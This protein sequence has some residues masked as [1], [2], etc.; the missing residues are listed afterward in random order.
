MCGICGEIRFDAS[1][2][3]ISAIDRV[4]NDVVVVLEE[5]KDLVL[6]QR[7]LKEGGYEPVIASNAADAEVVIEHD[8]PALAIRPPGVDRRHEPRGACAD[9]GNLFIGHATLPPRAR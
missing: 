3:S 5:F 7:L 6:V 2:P 9:D 1:S 8:D 4:G